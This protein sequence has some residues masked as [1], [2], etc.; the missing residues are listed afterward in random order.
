MKLAATLIGLF[1]ALVAGDVLAQ[2]KFSGSQ[3]RG[4]RSPSEAARGCSEGGV[5]VDI[6]RGLYYD[7]GQRGYND[8]RRNGT[9]ICRNNAIRSGLIASSDPNQ[10]RCRRYGSPLVTYAERRC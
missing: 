6:D 3:F 8:P 4:Y 9:F 2:S 10:L 7:E 5:W 1:V